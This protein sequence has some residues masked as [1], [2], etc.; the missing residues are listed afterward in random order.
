MAKPPRTRTELDDRLKDQGLDAKLFRDE[1]SKERSRWAEKQL[2][3]GSTRKTVR[4]I[5]ERS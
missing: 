5:R 4:D 3:L 2:R 1:E